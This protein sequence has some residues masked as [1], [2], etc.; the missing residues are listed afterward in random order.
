M[1]CDIHKAENIWWD[2]NGAHEEAHGGE[3]CWEYV[4]RNY[5][6]CKYTTNHVTDMGWI[7]IGFILI[8]YY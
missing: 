2:F 1:Y 8:M 4:P 6:L 3:T 5:Y 7:L